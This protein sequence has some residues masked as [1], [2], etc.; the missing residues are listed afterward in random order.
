MFSWGMIGWAD[1]IRRHDPPTVSHKNM[2]FR[3]SVQR[4]FYAKITNLDA[5]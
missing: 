5:R 1:A 3:N 4:Q 2:S